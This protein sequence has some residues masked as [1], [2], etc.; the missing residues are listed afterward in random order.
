MKTRRITRSM[1]GMAALL[2][3][4]TTGRPAQ[5]ATVIID[6]DGVILDGSSTD[7]RTYAEDGFTLTP[8]EG[9]VRISNLF[10]TVSKAAHP[11]FG[12]GAG[13]ASSFT[14]TNDSNLPFDAVS[15]DLLEGVLPPCLPWGVTVFG[16][17]ADQSIVTQTF[18]LDGSC[19]KQTFAFSSAF[20]GL[21]SLRIAEDSANAFPVD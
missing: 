11:S 18:P 21:V 6:F 3:L 5:A 9:F 2:L 16:T 20:T 14:F 15:I 12:F 13:S 7:F 19:A 1:V 8:S 17:K 10:S 4:C